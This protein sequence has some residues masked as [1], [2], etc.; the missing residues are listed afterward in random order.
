MEYSWIHKYSYLE[1]HMQRLPPACLAR[2]PRLVRLRRL[3]PFW[4]ALWSVLTS[5][6]SCFVSWARLSWQLDMP[7]PQR[8]HFPSQMLSICLPPAPVPASAPVPVP[9][10]C[11]LRGGLA[12]ERTRFLWHIRE[13]IV[14]N[15]FTNIL[16]FFI[17]I[18]FLYFFFSSYILQ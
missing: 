7:P 17:F 13:L 3:A 1:I 12:S 5:N 6:A 15:Y 10:V 16:L 4:T 18:L 9:K 14:M 11:P 2:L 8:H